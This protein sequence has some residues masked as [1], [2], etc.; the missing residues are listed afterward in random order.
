MDVLHVGTLENIQKGWTYSYNMHLVQQQ[1]TKYNA[2]VKNVLV[3]SE[4]M[5]AK[6]MSI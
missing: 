5:K 4:E 1:A 6:F 2:P 3:H